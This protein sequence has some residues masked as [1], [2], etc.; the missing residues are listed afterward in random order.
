MGVFDI[1]SCNTSE[2]TVSLFSIQLFG[3]TLMDQL[4]NYGGQTYPIIYTMA[5]LKKV[6]F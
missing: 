3:G 2:N 5:F 1:K 4:T 6:H